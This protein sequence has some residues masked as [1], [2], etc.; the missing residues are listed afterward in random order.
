[1]R[2]VG[3]G[4]H[5]A[6]PRVGETFVGSRTKEQQCRWLPKTTSKDNERW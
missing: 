3:R 5:G 2:L 6:I 4:L 1:M